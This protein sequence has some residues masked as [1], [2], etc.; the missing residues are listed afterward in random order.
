MVSFPCG[1]IEVA[2]GECPMAERSGR[3]AGQT[4][5]RI[6]A[7][8]HTRWL[9]SGRYHDF[10]EAVSSTVTRRLRPGTSDFGGLGHSR[11]GAALCVVGC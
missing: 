5:V 2:D 4:R 8:L 11:P 7:L 10:P 3:A 1:A 9:P 6:R